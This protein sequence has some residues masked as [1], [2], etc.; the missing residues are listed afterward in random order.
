MADET[1]AAEALDAVRWDYDPAVSTLTPLA[2]AER[3]FADFP[4]EGADTED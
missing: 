2:T 3:W 4:W 1:A